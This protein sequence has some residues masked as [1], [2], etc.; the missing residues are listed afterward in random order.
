MH[1]SA[2]LPIFMLAGKAL[3]VG[4][5]TH[6]FGTC[7]DGI[8]HWYDPDDGQIC[9]PFDCGGGRAPPRTD[10]PGCPQYKGTAIRQT[11]PSYMPCFGKATSTSSA[12]AAATQTP[13][14]TDS[15]TSTDTD[16]ATDSPGAG[17][18]STSS[19]TL[20]T[21]RVTQSV[22][23][24]GTAAPPATTDPAA[25]PSGDDSE[26]GAAG[27]GQSSSSSSTS[28]TAAANNAG[29]VWGG[30]M[31]AAAGVAVGAVVLL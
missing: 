31:M 3:A 30:S 20:V 10:V 12:S 5:A 6:T 26:S 17:P 29:K 15:L 25:L 4:C 7:A 27:P 13:A 11:T 16:T 28:T 2:A 9:D 8:V 14:D 19:S 1:L 22:T 24:S 23:S 21:S 18:T